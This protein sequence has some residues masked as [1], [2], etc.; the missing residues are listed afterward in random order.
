MHGVDLKTGIGVIGTR[1]SA[2]GA[3]P[4]DTR[5]AICAGPCIGPYITAILVATTE[6]YFVTRA[7]TLARA[8]QIVAARGAIVWI[9][10]SAGR[11]DTALTHGTEGRGRPFDTPGVCVAFTGAHGIAAET[12]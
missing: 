5:S 10:S 8:T 3:L 11:A 6:L 1:T 4:V 7:L 2:V 9:I 12:F